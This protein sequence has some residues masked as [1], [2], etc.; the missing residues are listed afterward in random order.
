MREARQRGLG[1]LHHSLHPAH[2]SWLNQVEIDIGLFARHCQHPPS[3]TIGCSS[4][5]QGLFSCVSPSYNSLPFLLQEDKNRVGHAAIVIA[6]ALLIAGWWYARNWVLHPAA[7]H[8]E[9]PVTK[10]DLGKEH[11]VDC[12]APIDRQDRVEER[13]SS[14]DSSG[15]KLL[16][17]ECLCWS[18]WPFTPLCQ[19]LSCHAGTFC[20][21]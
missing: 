13:P 7:N 1:P 11:E 16:S 17:R 12:L 10:P 2:G 9:T 21:W 4:A 5:H 6:L 18:V 15:L 3:P 8:Q 19:T 14:S 20:F